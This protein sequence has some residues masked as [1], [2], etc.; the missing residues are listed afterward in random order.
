M[1]STKRLVDWSNADVQA[2]LTSSDLSQ[3]STKFA[4]FDGRQLRQLRIMYRA[5]PS[6]P[7]YLAVRKLLKIEALPDLLTLAHCLEALKDEES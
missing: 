4:A 5:S 1:K 3:L 7:F 6:A 2:W